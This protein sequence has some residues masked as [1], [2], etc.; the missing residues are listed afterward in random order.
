MQIRGQRVPRRTV[1]KAGAAGGAL[2]ATGALPSIVSAVP[3]SAAAR[4]RF[5]SSDRELHLLRRATFGAT[6]ASLK[7]LRRLGRDEWLDRQLHPE[8]IP[9]RVADD[10]LARFPDLD[11][12]I[13]TA[14]QRLEGSW[15]LMFDLGV[16]TLARA[17]WSERQLFEVMVDFWSNHLNVTN[18]SDMVW[19]SRH[20]YDRTVIRRH[21]LGRFSDMLAASA[22]H[23]AMLLYLNNAESTFESPNENYGRELL[24]LHSVGVDGGYDEDD[25]RNSALVMTGFGINWDDGTYEYHP[26]AHH[27]GPLKVMSWR[28]KNRRRDGQDVGLD[29]VDYLAR[30]PSTARHLATKLARRFVSD[31]PPRAL[32]ESLAEVYLDNGT[33]ITPV[34]RA[35]FRSKTFETSVGEK[36]RR[37]LEDLAATVRTLGVGPDAN[38]TDGLIGLYWMVEGL[39]QAPLAWSQPDGYPDVADAW[40]SAGGMLSRWNS[41]MSLAAHWWPEDLQAPKLGALVPKPLPNTHGALVDALARRLVFRALSASHRKA[42]L[43]F[44]GRRPGDPLSGDDE[45][46]GWRLPYLVSLILDSPYHMVR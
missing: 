22:R 15:Q 6:R 38:G 8:R 10:I 24:E 2:V 5:V 37:P 3:A 41:H 43:D 21:A 1:L 26:W 9:D 25:M 42:V 18:P 28:S 7:E 35:L 4:A 19:F 32:V 27:V 45:A 30:H 20:D 44:I 17:A 46:V 23:P 39:G 13:T 34:L 36:V 31:D 16:S 14:L 33:A 40:R 12:S 11:W 29:Y